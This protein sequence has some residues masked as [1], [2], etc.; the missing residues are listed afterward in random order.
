[1]DVA[2]PGREPVD[3]ENVKTI[4]YSGKLATYERSRMSGN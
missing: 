1:M 2:V 4:S 3:R